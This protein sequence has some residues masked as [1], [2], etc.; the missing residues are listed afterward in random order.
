[1]V[2][3]PSQIQKLSENDFLG[4]VYRHFLGL[5]LDYQRIPL[6]MY[7]C[8]VRLVVRDVACTF[9]DHM[10]KLHLPPELSEIIIKENL[11]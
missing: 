10:S 8:R 11:E 5:F 1:M 9:S 3:F 6:I 2:C 7:M 4:W